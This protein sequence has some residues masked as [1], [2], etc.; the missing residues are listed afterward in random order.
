LAI[1]STTTDLEPRYP[2]PEL[3][4]MSIAERDSRWARVRRLMERDGLDAIVTLHNSESWDQGNAN[5]RYLSSIGGNCAWVSVV[6]PREGEVTGVVGP[7]PAPD[8][9]L[10]SQSW[11]EDVRPAFFN[12]TPVVAERL[13]ELGLAKGRIGVSGLGPVPRAPDGLVNH[14]SLQVLEERLPEA[15]LVDA[16]GLLFEARF[17]K[18]E[19]E[20]A[21][22]TKAVAAVESGIE[23]L[24]RE[25]RAGIP[26]YAVYARMM[27]ALLE[28][29]SEPTTLLLWTAGNPL[30]P[31]A[32]TVPSH[33]PLGADDV[34]QIEADAKWCGYLGHV[35][36]TVWVGEPDATELEMAA[37]QME[38]TRR[39]W[40]AF[41]PGTSLGDFVDICADL[42]RGT[43]FKCQPII[44]GRGLGFDAPV[45]V[46][47]ARDERTRDWQLEENSVFVVKPRVA[48]RDDR[49]NVIWGDSVA[50]T[51]D[52][53]RRLGKGPPLI[54]ALERRSG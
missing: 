1:D 42:G 48:T 14:G 37:L 11:V 46:F 25:A 26:E 10:L 15:E 45:L 38:A 50:V 27:S 28:A 52:G 22:L 49:R 17:V 23:T 40:D 35:S 34:I 39:C 9:W 6:F 12:L 41:R 47:E 8:Y 24:E 51:P 30:P 36:T 5:G 20:I 7:V 4:R 53:A 18:S 33:R 16:T 2:P 29:G 32:A 3:P 54:E 19:E 21:M 31:A 43:P 44:H 13:H